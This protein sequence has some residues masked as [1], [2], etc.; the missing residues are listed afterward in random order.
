MRGD[1]VDALLRRA[2]AAPGGGD[3]GAQAAR[4]AVVPLGPLA[5]VVAPETVPFRPAG[6]EL[7][8]AIAARVPGLGDY[9]EVL[10]L[11]ELGDFNQGRGVRIEHPA[12][13]P[14]APQL[15]GEV[16]AEA[17]D[18]HLLVPVGEAVLDEPPHR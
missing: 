9:L 15:V 11:G 4:L 6:G 1:E 17:V 3:G 13:A 14:L 8:D 10:V 7:A 12:V 5:H 16:E 2:E 18:A